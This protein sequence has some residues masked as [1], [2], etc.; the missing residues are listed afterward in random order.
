[1]K[2]IKRGVGA[3]EA[4]LLDQIEKIEGWLRENAELQQCALPEA[5]PELERE[6]Q[7]LEGA[8]GATRERLRVGG[9]FW[10]T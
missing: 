5:L 7:M 4:D 8:L 3:T 9:T 2:A 6:G 10:H 1:M